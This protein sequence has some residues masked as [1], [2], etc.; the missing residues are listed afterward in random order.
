MSDEVRIVE[1]AG[2]RVAIAYD[3]EAGVWYVQGSTVPGLAG[4][5]ASAADLIAELEV[6][7]RT[8]SLP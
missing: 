7:V 4:E 2:Q 5:A 3:A 8:L 6:A 1:I